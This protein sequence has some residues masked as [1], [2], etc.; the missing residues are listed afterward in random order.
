M[1]NL[2]VWGTI[3]PW[4]L[5]P[6][7]WPDS[8]ARWIWYTSGARTSAPA[9][10]AYF[11][12]QYTATAT[13]E[14]TVYFTADNSASLSVD[15]VPMGANISDFTA[16]RAVPVTLAA[17]PH[18]FEIY[19]E[20]QAVGAAGLLVTVKSAAGAVLLSTASYATKW[21]WSAT[22][23]PYT[24]CSPPPPPPSPT[25]SIIGVFLPSALSRQTSPASRAARR[26]VSMLALLSS[27]SGCHTRS[28]CAC[29]ALSELLPTHVA[30]ADSLNGP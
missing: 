17:G 4:N 5:R 15:G 11:Y 21:S 16:I 3:T 13:V 9:A 28:C 19:A 27:V 1:Y 6:V 30:K 23:M 25:T 20:N 26:S 8:T 18:L 12:G 10:G 24:Q 14:A 22:A 29:A 2:G 7:G